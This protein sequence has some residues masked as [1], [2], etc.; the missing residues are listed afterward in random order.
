MSSYHKRN[1]QLLIEFGKFVYGTDNALQDLL[2]KAGITFTQLPT[3]RGSRA[4]R[5][6]RTP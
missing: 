5:A 6:R 2:A 3:S 4:S 1:M